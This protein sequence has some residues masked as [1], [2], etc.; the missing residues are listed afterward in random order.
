MKRTAITLSSILAVGLAA[1]LVSHLQ[2]QN[3]GLQ[4]V[5]A[6]APVATR[7]AVINLMGVVKQY[8]K[9]KSFEEAYK[10][11]VGQF[12]K[13]FEQK[14]D[15]LVELKK[16]LDATLENDKRDQIQAQMKEVERAGQDLSEQAKKQLGK[17]REDNAVQIYREVQ[18]AAERYARAHGIGVVLEYAD[19]LTPAEIYHPMNVMRKLQTQPC[20]PLYVDPDM[21]I[22]NQV[23]AMLQ[24]QMGLQANPNG[25]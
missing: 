18:A 10:N 1:Y 19:A 3:N 11:S 9:G 20:V 14:K 6:A 23:V 13:A 2:A 21:D 12:E 16:R 17:Y 5:N 25:R 4:Q 24:Q 7:M 15:A 22:T 8:E